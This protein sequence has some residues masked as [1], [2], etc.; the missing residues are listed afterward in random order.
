MRLST[1]WFGANLTGE[2]GT[3]QGTVRLT[4]TGDGLLTDNFQEI[5]LLNAKQKVVPDKLFSFIELLGWDTATPA[6]NIDTAFLAQFRDYGNYSAI[7]DPQL[8]ILP[9]PTGKVKI[10]WASGTLVSSATLQGTYTA[11]PG[12]TSPWL[13]TPS[14]G[15]TFYRVQQ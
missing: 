15:A 14:G 1:Y 3:G 13:A 11:V 10:T 9:D 4:F 12:A 8:K 2:F 5:T 6:T 7:F